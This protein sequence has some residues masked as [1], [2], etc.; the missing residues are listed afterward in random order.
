M[1]TI[2]RI[3]QQHLTGELTCEETL[4]KVIRLYVN[5]DNE[6]DSLIRKYDEKKMFNLN[7]LNKYPGKPEYEWYNSAFCHM[8][9]FL[10][11]LKDIKANDKIEEFLINK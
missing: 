6:I 7:N 5:I 4:D 1:K 9:I 10:R 3:I 11:D 8:V 2:D